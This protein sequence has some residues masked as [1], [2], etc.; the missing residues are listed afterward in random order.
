[1]QHNFRPSGI[2]GCFQAGKIAD[3]ADHAGHFAFQPSQGE[4]NNE[5]C[6][7]YRENEPLDGFDPYSNS[8]SCSELVTHS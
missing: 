2:K 6:W 7:G 8:K 3:V 1:M 5:W 4:Q